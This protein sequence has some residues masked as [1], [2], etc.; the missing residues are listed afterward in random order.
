MEQ[1]SYSGQSTPGR[2][3]RISPREWNK[4]HLIIRHLYIEEDKSL[5]E[6]MMIMQEEH[7]FHAR[8]C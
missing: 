7:G 6:T 4:H 8:Y 2:R 3:R 1:H 5:S